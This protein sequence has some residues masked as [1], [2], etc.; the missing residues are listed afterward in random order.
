[1]DSRPAVLPPWRWIPLTP[2]TLYVGMV[3]GAQGGGVFKSTDAGGTW[4]PLA[5]GLGDTAV[6]AL[7][8]DPTTPTTVYA[9]TADMGVFDIEQGVATTMCGGDCDGSGDVT[10]NEIITLVNIDLG[11]ADASACPHGVPSDVGVDITLI[12]KA[13][14]YALTNCPAS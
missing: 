5:V 12:I 7:A 6:Y 11:L 14:G 8:V 3:T 1:M 10:V 13:V 9:G 2:G 4:T